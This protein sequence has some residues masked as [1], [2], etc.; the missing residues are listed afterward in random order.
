MSKICKKNE[1]FNAPTTSG[2]KSVNYAP[3]IVVFVLLA[4]SVGIIIFSLTRQYSY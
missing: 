4:L 3:I 2:S 1:H